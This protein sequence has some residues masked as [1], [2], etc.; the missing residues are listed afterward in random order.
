MVLIAKSSLGGTSQGYK[1]VSLLNS[2][3]KILHKIL[4]N[5]IAPTLCYT[6]NANQGDLT[7]TPDAAFLLP[8]LRELIHR[9]S[10]IKKP[11][12]VLTFDAKQALDRVN[13]SFLSDLL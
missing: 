7:E 10:A 2:D 4:A 3:N 5:R 6:L 12:S 9:A 8:N 13:I 1:L 11:R